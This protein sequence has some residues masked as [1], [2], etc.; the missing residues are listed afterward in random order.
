MGFDELNGVGYIPSA[1]P[2]QLSS[3]ASIA[4][5]ELTITSGTPT[6]TISVTITAPVQVQLCEIVATIQS[7][8]TSPEAVTFT[9]KLNEK[10]IFLASSI[11]DT[12]VNG[13]FPVYVI[14]QPVGTT[15]FGSQGDQVKLTATWGAGSGTCVCTGSIALY[16][17]FI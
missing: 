2:F 16:G 3:S 1:I 7:S 8:T 12:S 4:G 14:K 15:F 9:V 6:K 11:A 5:G 13:F 10:I 17:V